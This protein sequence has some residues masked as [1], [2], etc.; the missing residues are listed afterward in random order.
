MKMSLSNKPG[1]VYVVERAAHHQLFF[2]SHFFGE[3]M[4]NER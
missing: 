4:L 3:L 1:F 2:L